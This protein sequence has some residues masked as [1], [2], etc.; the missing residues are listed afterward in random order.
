MSGLGGLHVRRRWPSSLLLG[1]SLTRR[2]WA[3]TASHALARSRFGSRVAGGS[4]RPRLPRIRPHTLPM[5]Y[6][7]VLDPAALHVAGLP[8]ALLLDRSPR[9]LP[10]AD[11]GP[12]PRGPLWNA[13]GLVAAGQAAA[14]ARAP[15]E[16]NPARGHEDVAIG[17]G[18][19]ASHASWRPA[20]P[21]LPAGT[22]LATSQV[23]PAG[24]AN[25]RRP[26]IGRLAHHV[27]LQPAREQAS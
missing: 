1:H 24:V 21:T 22:T 4:G 26:C 25:H 7:P 14:T 19:M 15:S 9:G 23:I 12:G 18:L 3:S 11:R 8:R 13:G 2:A 20:R 5:S 27:M 10:S 17:A 16:F 6:G